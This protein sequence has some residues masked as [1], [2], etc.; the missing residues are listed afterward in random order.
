MLLMAKARGF[1]GSALGL[2]TCRHHTQI[3]DYKPSRKPSALDRKQVLAQIRQ[4][5][6]HTLHLL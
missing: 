4:S 2:L 1:S 6:G 3:G 5:F